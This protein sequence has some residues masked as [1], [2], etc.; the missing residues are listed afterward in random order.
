MLYRL[1]NPIHS[2]HAPFRITFFM[3]KYFT[4]ADVGKVAD[5]SAAFTLSQIGLHSK[6]WNPTP[7]PPNKARLRVA[8]PNYYSIKLQRSNLSTA[9][10]RG[11]KVC[12]WPHLVPTYCLRP[13][14]HWL[15][16]LV[17]QLTIHSSSRPSSSTGGASSPTVVSLATFDTIT[18]SPLTLGCSTSHRIASR[19]IPCHRAASRRIALLGLAF[20]PTSTQTRQTY[21]HHGLHQCQT[22]LEA[23]YKSPTDAAPVCG[24]RD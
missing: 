19:A 12:S 3:H 11:V 8:T 14:C 22:G 6:T 15:S 13:G 4:L 18:P 2:N 9:L 7:T 5:W 24:F 17:V 23:Q 1:L 16:V 21:I 10:S 20:Q